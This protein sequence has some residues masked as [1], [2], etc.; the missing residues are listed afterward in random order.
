MAYHSYVQ[1]PG[2][3]KEHVRECHCSGIFYLYENQ[4]LAL[5]ADTFHGATSLRSIDFRRNQISHIDVNAF[6][7]L[8]NLRSL[9][10]GFNK[11]VEL[12]GKIFAPVNKL[13]YL[14]FYQ[15][16]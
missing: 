4:I 14:E 1:C 2:N 16:S 8:P 7:G 11:I 9:D 3:Q 5:E 10:L 6:R 12:D 15:S 13:D